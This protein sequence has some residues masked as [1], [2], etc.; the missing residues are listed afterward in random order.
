MVE[1][2]AETLYCTAL[3]FSPLGELLGKHRKLM[4]TPAERLVWVSATGPR[5]RSSMPRSDDWAR[6]SAGR[7][8]CPCCGRTCPQQGVQL[9]CAPTAD[10]RETWV[11]SM[12]HVAAAGRCFVLAANQFARR[13]DYPADYPLDAGPDEILST[14]NSMIVSPLGEILAGPVNGQ[15]NILRTSLDLDTIPEGKYDF[16]AVG[17]Y[18]RPDVFQLTVDTRAQRA[19][20]PADRIPADRIPADGA[21]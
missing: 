19:V 11:A 18:A 13:A 9:Y 3:M 1:R 17:H 14:G 7:T 15:E 12:R 8:T 4:P 21:S 6:S 10:P 2:A 5:C 16:D 20:I